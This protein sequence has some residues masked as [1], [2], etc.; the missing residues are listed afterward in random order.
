MMQKL[1]EQYVGSKQWKNAVEVALKRAEHEPSSAIKAKFYY[2]AGATFRDEIKGLDEAVEYFNLAL[3][4][5]MK[6]VTGEIE[7]SQL[8]A[9]ENIER[10]L[11]G[12]KDYKALERSYRKMIRRFPAEGNLQLRGLLVHSLGEIY[13][14]NLKD[15]KASTEAFAL[16]SNLEPEN[17]LRHQILAELYAV[18]AVATTSPRR[19]RST[20]SCSS[21]SPTASSRTRRSTSCTWTPSSTT[22]PGASA[23]PW[24]SS[25]RQTRRSCSS[26]SSTGPRPS[27]GPSSA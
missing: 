25:R 20:S 8:K 4:E 15:M 7:P 3:D 19:S 18:R 13:R 17:A 16:A 2:F 11:R 12:K 23:R 5:Q 22:R 27:S 1:L 10:I 24:P 14:T 21:A 26:S 9:F 6:Q